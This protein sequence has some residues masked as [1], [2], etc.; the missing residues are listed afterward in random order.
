MRGVALLV[1]LCLA[2]PLAAHAD[3]LD[4]TLQPFCAQSSIA[5]PTCKCAGDVMRRAVP[6]GEMD[7]ILKFARNQLSADEIAKLPDGG[8]PLRA[9]FV[10]GWRQ[11]Q[12]EC[13]VKQ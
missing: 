4:D 2:Y 6:A 10:D 13:G 11:A 3:A 1:V 5:A 8:T 7:V 9:K 12:A